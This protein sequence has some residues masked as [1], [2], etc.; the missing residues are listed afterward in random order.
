M[1][2]VLDPGVQPTKFRVNVLSHFFLVFS[3]DV[4]YL[5]DHIHGTWTVAARAAT[6]LLDELQILDIVKNLTVKAIDQVRHLK[7]VNTH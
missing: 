1:F 7:K 5:F 4:L 3:I 2:E 6:D